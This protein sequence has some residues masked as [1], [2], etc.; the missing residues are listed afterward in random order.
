MDI[1][2]PFSSIGSRAAARADLCPGLL[3]RTLRLICP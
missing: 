1:L 2:T 3:L